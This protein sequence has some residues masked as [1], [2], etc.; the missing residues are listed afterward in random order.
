MLEE[1]RIW[2]KIIM[3]SSSKACI[4]LNLEGGGGAGKRREEVEEEDEEEDERESEEKGQEGRKEG[5]RGGE[6]RTGE[7]REH[8]VSGIPRL[9]PTQRV[10]SSILGHVPVPPHRS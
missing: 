4:V 5:G 7:R 10:A 1:V 3:I 2:G 9:T 6:R 8:S